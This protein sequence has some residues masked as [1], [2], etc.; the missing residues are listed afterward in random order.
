MGVLLTRGLTSVCVLAALALG[1]ERAELAL[2]PP[3][4]AGADIRLPVDSR[5]VTARVG[6][7]ETFAALLRGLAIAEAEAIALV[8]RASA[9]F[10]LRKL[11]VHQP[12]RLDL[13]RS[14]QVKRFEYEIDDDRRLVLTRSAQDGTG[15][16]ADVLPI[17][18]TSRPALVSGEIDRTAPSLFAAIA[19]AGEEV[20]LSVAMAD[21]FSSEVDFNTELQNGDR[22]QLL[23]EKEYRA[24]EAFSGYG[25]ILGG[26]IENDGRRVR[27]IRFT[28][29][30]GPAA[31]YDQDGRSLRRFF[32]RS[33]LKFDPTVTSGF[34]RSRLHP[35][36]GERRAH[37]GVDYR[38][39]SGAPVVAVADGLVVS[40][41]ANGGAGRMVHLRHANGF[42]TQ[43]LHLSSVAV[44]RGARVR[45]GD[46]VG[47]VG[48]TGLATG[49]HLDYRVRKN[50]S[51]INPVAAHR[52]MPPGE[53]VP[54]HE[55]EA[56]AAVR[57]RVL[58]A[59]ASADVL[60]ASRR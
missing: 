24:D 26:E 43:Y 13:S 32:L 19:R 5:T 27:A 18:K 55:L 14:D 60:P 33:P 58:S 35:V 17:E 39:P 9:V 20:D 37:L 41:G 2:P 54:A 22:F 42:E 53:P 28:P 57:D 52:A 7:G 29:S 51:F 30:H 23:V 25:A 1:C 56:F 15:F 31:Y 59:L 46:L 8:E 40:A 12:Y 34:S 3:P 50:G 47:R 48:A 45:Q 44:R 11:R 36:L 21:V 49:P 38:A 16:T 6:R 10:D 4:V